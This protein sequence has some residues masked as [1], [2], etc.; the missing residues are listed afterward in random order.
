MLFHT[1]QFSAFFL[2]VLVLFYG[3]PRP[4]RRWIL[5]AASYFFYMCWN[6]KFILLILALTAI[7]F[8]AALWIRRAATTP[9]R[10]AALMPHAF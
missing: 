10:K 6:A 4:A 9:R 8:A 3:L 5:L 7:D 1:P 2:V